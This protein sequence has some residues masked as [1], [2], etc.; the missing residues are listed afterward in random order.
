[1]WTVKSKALILFPSQA[2][3]IPRKRDDGL[4]MPPSQLVKHH[5]RWLCLPATW[6]TGYLE[7]FCFKGY[8]CWEQTMHTVVLSTYKFG[9]WSKCCLFR[10]AGLCCCDPHGDRF[11]SPPCKWSANMHLNSRCSPPI[12]I[13]FRH[14]ANWLQQNNHNLLIKGIL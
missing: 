5:R 7:V 1:M 14:R 4:W 8:N 10:W 11:T 9:R 3:I 2:T 6:F 13:K 12:H